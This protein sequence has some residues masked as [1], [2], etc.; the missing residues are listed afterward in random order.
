MITMTMTMMYTVWI[1]EIKETTTTIVLP[2]PIPTSFLAINNR[3]IIPTPI[4][5]ML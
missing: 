2:L 4:Q 3:F 5:D 1:E